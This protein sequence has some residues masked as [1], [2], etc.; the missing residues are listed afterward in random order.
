M[1]SNRL[2]GATVFAA[3]TLM[4]TEAK[5][6]EDEVT[7][8]ANN[9]SHE[10][11]ICGVYHSLVAQCLTNRDPNDRWPKATVRPR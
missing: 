1:M 5:A 4:A 8:I 6:V 9:F 11:L 10:N 2:A 3:L 7:R